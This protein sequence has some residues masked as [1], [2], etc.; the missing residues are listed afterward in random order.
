MWKFFKDKKYI[1]LC[2]KQ[3]KV[4]LCYHQ[5]KIETNS[6]SECLCKSI[7]LSYEWKY[8]FEQETL[9]KVQKGLPN[10]PRL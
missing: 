1:W 6:E 4:S 5:E 10:I 8:D 9:E 2:Q 3:N 7:L